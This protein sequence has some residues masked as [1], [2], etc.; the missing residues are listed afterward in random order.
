MDDRK[1]QDGDL[2]LGAL[3]DRLHDHLRATAERPVE[4]SASRWLGEAEAVAGDAG[5]TG[6][7]ERVA[8]ARAVVGRIVARC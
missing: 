5:G 2:D 4:R 3:A 7:R 1:S 8:E 6:D